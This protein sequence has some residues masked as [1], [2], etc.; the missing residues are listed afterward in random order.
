MGLSLAH[1]RAFG[2]VIASG[3]GGCG[4]DGGGGGRQSYS[5]S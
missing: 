4:V 1:S 2:L 3:G 5:A